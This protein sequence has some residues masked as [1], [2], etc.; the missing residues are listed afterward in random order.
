MR[1]D[2][3]GGSKQAS[4]ALDATAR[5]G[6]VDSDSDDTVDFDWQ[7]PDGDIW[8]QEPAPEP[9]QSR[10]DS[11]KPQCN[12]KGGVDNTLNVSR[13]ELGGTILINAL[14]KVSGH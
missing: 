9:E 6:A 13:V 8:E 3:R 10:L 14:L 7:V 1:V 11:I 5:L 4:A 2:E 12:K